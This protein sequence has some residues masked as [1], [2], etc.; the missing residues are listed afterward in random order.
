[1]ECAL[2]FGASLLKSVGALRACGPPGAWEGEWPS[3]KPAPPGAGGK[4]GEPLGSEAVTPVIVEKRAAWWNASPSGV[5]REAKQLES[6]TNRL[7]ASGRRGETSRPRDGPP[8]T[9]GSEVQIRRQTLWSGSALFPTRGIATPFLAARASVSRA[10]LRDS[11]GS[12][13]SIGR[14]TE[15]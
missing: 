15:A 10:V 14:E 11:T 7:D 1:M 6:T 3:R 5:E 8:L 13:R 9:S 12:R 2:P 4:V